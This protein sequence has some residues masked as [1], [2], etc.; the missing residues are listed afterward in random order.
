MI[1]KPHQQ[2]EKGEDRQQNPARS[3]FHSR[4]LTARSILQKVLL[5]SVL[6]LTLVSGL[7]PGDARASVVESSQRGFTVKLGF[8]TS[9]SPQKVFNTLVQDVGQWWSSSHTFSGE[10]R[11]LSIEPRPQGCFCER[12]GGNAG[13]VHA[14]V[15][16]VQPGKVL[17][18]KGA[19]GPLQQ[20]PVT[21]VFTFEMGVQGGKTRLDLTYR[22]DG[23]VPGE[24]LAAR[25]AGPVDQVLSEQIQRL[26]NLI[27]TGHPEEN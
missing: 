7:L 10:A 3:R 4:R 16:R 19:L 25:W 24:G 2:Q 17:V 12:F 5:P 20:L 23:Y 14:T 26:H 11:N 6:S 13:V 15:I 8:E 27:D 9:A 22:V 18:M 21:G 1:N